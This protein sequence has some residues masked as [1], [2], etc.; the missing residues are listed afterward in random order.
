MEDLAWLEGLWVGKINSDYVEEVWTKATAGAMMGMFRWV[1]KGRLRLYEFM[2]I[3]QNGKNIEMRIKH[4]DPDLSGWEEKEESTV[5]CLSELSDRQ[6]VFFQKSESKPLW[7]VYKSPS[8][9]TL[10]LYFEP[11]GNSPVGDKVFSF[12][13][14]GRANVS[15]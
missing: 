12:Q 2:T 3:A 5:F 4:F 6:A 10:R 13:R 7:L 15:G 1:T 8:E 9:S 14:V 11:R